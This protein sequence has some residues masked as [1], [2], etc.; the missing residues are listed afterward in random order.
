M[1]VLDKQTPAPFFINFP[2]RVQAI[3]A[4]MAVEGI[5]VYLGTRLRT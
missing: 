5:D 3:Q 1:N 4:E 2:W